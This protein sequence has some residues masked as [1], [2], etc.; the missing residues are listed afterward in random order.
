MNI[1]TIIVDDERLARERIRLLL[2]GFPE[3]HL[4]G[5]C[6]NGA[7]A[8][9]KLVAERIDL[10]FLDIQMP[11]LD[12]IALI[13]KV[14]APRLPVVIF[15]TAYD[16]FAVKA[17][18]LNAVD[19]LLKPFSKERFR[20]ALSRAK[21]QL[22]SGDRDRYFAQVMTAVHSVFEKQQYLQ[23]VVVKAG[24]RVWFLPVGEVQ[25]VES[26]ANYLKVHAG[27]DTPLI[28]ET[29]TN[30]GE[31][32]D[33]AIF[34][35]IHRSVLVNITFIKEVKPWFNDEYTVVLKDGTQLPVGRTYRKSIINL[36]KM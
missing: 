10:M 16:S 14:P 11:E 27:K 15:T 6:A 31:K 20:L 32:L 2:K 25:W 28:R 30:F 7:E 8:L 29:L 22:E 18:E 4:V 26:E 13:E 21:Q 19:Y 24:G 36:L 23:R 3:L 34:L 33:P 17:F 9:R 5:E 1:Q 35:R 12:G